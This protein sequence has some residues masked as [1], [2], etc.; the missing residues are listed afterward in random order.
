[1]TEAA[2]AAADLMMNYMRHGLA[3]GLPQ[4]Q[5]AEMR[6]K[7]CF[8]RIHGTMAVALRLPTVHLQHICVAAPLLYLVVLTQLTLLSVLPLLC[9][10]R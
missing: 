3:A 7:C 2:I 8:L 9:A 1:M 10:S 4:L 5:L 6:W